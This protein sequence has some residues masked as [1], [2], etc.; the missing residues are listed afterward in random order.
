MSLNQTIKKFK[1]FFTLIFGFPLT[2]L[3][4]YF[5]IK[6]V[7]ENQKNIPKD[8]LHFEPITFASGIFF[9]FLFFL[10]R[11]VG[12]RKIL[13]NQ[14]HGLNLFKSTYLFWSSE[15]K[16]YIPGN[17]FSF[18]SR[19]S[20]FKKE[21]VPAKI[22]LKSLVEESLLITSS[23]GIFSLLS[24]PIILPSFTNI[25][26]NKFEQYHYFTIFAPIL[27]LA[28]I[29]T[30]WLKRK[31]LVR[32]FKNTSIKSYID[33]FSVYILGWF[34]F[35]VANFLIASSFS[36]LNPNNF[37]G[38]VSYFVFS[39]IVGYLSF[40]TPMGLGVRELVL[41]LGL[42]LFLPLYVASYIAILLR[43]VLITSEMAFFA[44]S[45]LLQNI[46]LRLALF[47]K[48]SIS[49]QELILFLSTTSYVVY[50]TYVTFEKHLNFFTGRFDLGNMDQT[51]WNTI[52]GRI[53]LL[54]NP[55]HINIISRLAIHADFLLI[56]L[57]PLYLLWQDPRVLL[58][59]QTL[60]LGIGAIYLYA[61]GK[62]ILKNKNL[63]LAFS[64]SYLLNP[65]LQKQNLFDFHS[66]SLATT[67]LLASFYYLNKN[68]YFAF[69]ITIILSVLTK[70]NIYLVA[71]LYGIY[72]IFS[73]KKKAGIFLT[74]LSVLVF[75]FLVTKLIP[76]ARG[77][78]DHFALSYFGE[79]GSTP[80]EI[81]KNIFLEPLKTIG[82]IAT[83]ENINYII[84]LFIPV[85]FLSVF[86][87]LYIVFSSPD[88][89][90]NIL[91]NNQNLKSNNF[92]YAAAIIPFIFISAIYGAKKI[93]SLKLKIMSK[94]TLFYFLLI[95]AIF[96][97]WQYGVLPG[98][99]NPALEI[100]TRR[101]SDRDI[102]EQFLHKIPSNLSI[103]ATNNL[104][105]HLS[106]REKIYTIP[107]G[108]DQADVI[109]FLLNDEF[110]QPS[111]DEQKRMVENMKN[112]SNYVQVF[113]KGEF[114]VFEKKN[115]QIMKN[116]NQLSF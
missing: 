11:S 109:L 84:N 48:Y 115:L 78:S 24:L 81:L 56:L 110:A 75:T 32:Y 49:Y 89:L 112:N 62:D 106:H 13:K 96:S 16:R 40:V 102:I 64:I 12:W 58:F 47:K 52:N 6:I 82:V 105:A 74:A 68:R 76:Q 36:Y 90:L 71:S 23:A 92:H 25:I 104:G 98:S 59:T 95:M 31:A 21:K 107:I 7:Y 42:S 29:V 91:S 19:I 85:G 27:F 55:D 61:L 22:V 93:L 80:F 70:E 5:I 26:K 67:F 20:N 88:L 111:L 99:K 4:F 73:K 37:L 72:I 15:T 108:I 51:I 9:L 94:K 10:L 39:W 17:I 1:S 101:Q 44:L 43:I 2:A 34:F 114:K 8:F 50:F 46:K 38:I 33:V 57:S 65:Y 14:G 69:I 3:S 18:I 113:N 63:A 35:G 28:V 116:S 60:V 45:Y 86:S 53:F 87:P 97:T 100:Y 83:N 30:V 79:F 66:V 41:V 54:T 103:A 77:G